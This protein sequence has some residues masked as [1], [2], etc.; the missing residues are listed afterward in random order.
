MLLGSGSLAE[1]AVVT[2]DGGG[3]NK[4]WSEPLNWSGDALPGPTDS[5]VFDGTSSKDAQMDIPFTIDGLTIDVGYTG[6]VRLQAD[7]TNTGA[8]IQNAGTFKPGNNTMTQVGDWTFNAGTFSENASTI[9]FTGDVQTVDH[10]A[11]SFNHV[12]IDLTGASQIL[13]VVGTMDVNGRLTV[14][15][16][17][18]IDGAITVAKDVTTTDGAVGGTASITLDGAAAQTI[19]ATGDFPDGTFTVDKSAGT[20]TVVAGALSV[21]ALTITTGTLDLNGFDLSVTNA[22]T[23]GASGTLELFGSETLSKGSISLSPGSTVRYTG[24]GDGLA[25]NFSLTTVTS[26][27]E[28]LAIDA[29]DG[30]LDS[31]TIAG[32]VTVAGTLTLTQGELNHDT[33]A[34]NSLTL[35]GSGTAISVGATTI[36]RN[37]STATSTITLGGDVSVSGTVDF[38]S[39]G[40]G[41]GDADVIFIRSSI[42]G[43]QRA[44]TGAGSVSMIDVDVQDQA[45]TI[46]ISLFDGINSGK[47]WEQLELFWRLPLPLPD[48]ERGQL[49]F[50]WHR[51]GNPL[52]DRR[53]LD[54]RRQYHGHLCQRRRPAPRYWRR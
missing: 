22:L 34:A 36:W 18:T 31:F 28:N 47:Q 13:T 37:E 38:N 11:E 16:A 54:Y 39:S 7:L 44:W 45:G 1:A 33:V 49:P 26:N 17:T 12:E 3:G 52:S 24:D 27:Y 8:F 40:G 41:C 5:V 32:N 9:R 42:P 21:E 14:T 51:F 30:T 25:D 53:R 48:G 15:S 10:G 29:P 2:W 6:T 19:T 4:K 43:T 46:A 23:V 50:D 20:A 35:S